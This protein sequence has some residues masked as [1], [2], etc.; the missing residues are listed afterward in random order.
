MSATSLPP[1]TG[2]WFRLL[3][4]GGAL[5]PGKIALMRAVIAEGSVSGAARV[6]RMSHAR[7]VKLVAELNALAP[8][9]LIDT[10]AGG[11]AGGG[12]SVTPLG[13]AVLDAWVALDVAVQAAAEQKLAALAALLEPPT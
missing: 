10:R 3:L 11:P 9:P 5:G 8:S 12:A 4:P 13:L 7:S 6:L 1:R 2:L